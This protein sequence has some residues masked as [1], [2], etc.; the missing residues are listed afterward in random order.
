MILNH[1]STVVI[2][3]LLILLIE[4]HDILLNR[5]ESFSVP[6]R[7]HGYVREQAAPEGNRQRTENIYKS[8]LTQ[9]IRR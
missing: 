6:A 2:L 7:G 3:A 8:R 9:T 4:N 5:S 1:Y